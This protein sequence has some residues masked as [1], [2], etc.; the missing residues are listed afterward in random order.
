MVVPSE[1]PI[2]HLG[3]RLLLQ[4]GATRTVTRAWPL[5]RDREVDD[6]THISPISIDRSR[7]MGNT[8]E[9][10]ALQR[11]KTPL[12][13]NRN[14]EGNWRGHVPTRSRGRRRRGA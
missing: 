12:K 5:I 3:R 1:K 4:H 2:M 13:F 6:E 10:R 7:F 14:A 8:M 9:A 11:A